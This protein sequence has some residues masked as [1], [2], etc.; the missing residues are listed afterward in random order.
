MRQ[1]NISMLWDTLD[2][3]KKGYYKAEG[4][5]VKMKLSRSEMTEAEVYYPADIEKCALTLTRVVSVAPE[6]QISAVKT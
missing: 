6:G 3:V 2:I 1:D 4:E 5:T